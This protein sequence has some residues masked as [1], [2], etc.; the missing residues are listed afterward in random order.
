MRATN[1]QELRP[2]TPSEGERRR[3]RWL[4]LALFVGPF[5]WSTDFALSYGLTPRACTAQSAVL[6]LVFSAVALLA[7]ATGLVVA[8]RARREIQTAGGD[9]GTIQADARPFV[10]TGAL[11]TSTGFILVIVA[12][13]IPRL[14]LN[15]C[16]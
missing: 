3:R 1:V 13:A 6:L 4:W 10:V 5:A 14:V 11:V 8:L 9:T 16:I 2:G 7:A 12:G 15:P